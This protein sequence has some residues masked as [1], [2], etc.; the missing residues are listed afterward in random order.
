[1]ADM[2][3]QRVDSIFNSGHAFSIL[4]YKPRICLLY[5]EYT[6]LNA[7]MKPYKLHTQDTYLKKNM[8]Y[9][10]SIIMQ[11]LTYILSIR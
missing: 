8:K 6:L 2:L 4:Q 3:N 7:Y 10:V 9:K 11:T 5:R 1:M